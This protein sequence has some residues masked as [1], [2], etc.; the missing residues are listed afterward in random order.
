MA[1]TDAFGS[2]Y[3]TKK[4]YHEG[5]VSWIIVPLCS[6]TQSAIGFID[7]IASEAFKTG[8]T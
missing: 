5:K 4:A 8:L 2:R 3:L 7:K 6:D 1:L